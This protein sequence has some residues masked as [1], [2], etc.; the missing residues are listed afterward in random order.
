MAFGMR[1]VSGDFLPIVKY[2]ARNGT[3]TRE[4][5]QPDG[6]RVPTEI[7][8]GTKFAVDFGTIE[9]GWI[10]FTA[11][12]PVRV[13]VPYHEGV[14]LPAQ[15]QDKDGEGKLIFK[16]GFYVKVCGKALDGAREWAGN[17]VCLLN[18]LEELYQTY[19]AAPEAAAGQIPIVTIAGKLPIKTGSGL[20]SSTNWY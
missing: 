19:L 11:Q 14:Q 1:T 5:K 9:A 18:A 6:S 7:P 12:G 16:S 4:D 2:D 13:M 3:M 10:T 17:A 15:P 20:K 8:H